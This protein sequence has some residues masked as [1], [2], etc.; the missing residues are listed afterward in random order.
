MD[1]TPRSGTTPPAGSVREKSRTGFL[2]ASLAV[3]IAFLIGFGWQ[4]YEANTVRDDLAAIED[5]L[6][7]ERLRTQL[8]QAALN[9]QAGDYESARQQMS[10]FFRQ[11]QENSDAMPDA[12]RSVADDFLDDRDQIITGL[13]RSNPET[14]ATLYRML[15]ELSSAIDQPLMSGREVPVGDELDGGSQPDDTDGGSGGANT[16]TT[17]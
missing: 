11:L 4:F 9:A 3:V 7:L 2:W 5:E 1:E 8:G 17:D 13:S 14:A 15:G 16:G 12:V 6:M 10:D